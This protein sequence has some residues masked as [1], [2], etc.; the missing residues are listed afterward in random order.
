MTDN[1][2]P[3]PDRATFKWA[4][5][6]RSRLQT[7]A[8]GLWDAL[9]ALQSAESF[10]SNLEMYNQVCDQIDLLEDSPECAKNGHIWEYA[11]QDEPPSNAVYER[12]VVCRAVQEV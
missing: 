6:E 7:L 1:P 4:L 12:C 11:W 10:A 2:T 8:D 3:M 5:D 9:D